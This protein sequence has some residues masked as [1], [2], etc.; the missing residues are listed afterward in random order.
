MI[1]I[2]MISVIDEPME[3]IASDVQDHD[4]R[5]C[6]IWN[7][8]HGDM[9]SSDLHGA[10]EPTRWML[11]PHQGEE[12]GQWLIRVFHQRRR[13][14]SIRGTLVEPDLGGMTPFQWNIGLGRLKTPPSSP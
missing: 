12:I 6:T 9:I 2:A 3:D 8:T 11:I 7:D 5:T 4:R 1:N 13:G 10:E 14:H